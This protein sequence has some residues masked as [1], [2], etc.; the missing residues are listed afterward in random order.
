MEKLRS[1]TTRNRKD[2]PEA[3]SS[4][5]SVNLDSVLIAIENMKHEVNENIN[6]NADKIAGLKRSFEQYQENWTDA[7]VEYTNKVVKLDENL[8]SIT[9]TVEQLS[10]AV[11]EIGEKI[12]REKLPIEEAG[13]SS[14]SDNPTQKATK[15]SAKNKA[16]TLHKYVKS[17]VR[18]H[19]DQARKVLDRQ[20]P[21]GTKVEWNFV[22]DLTKGIRKPENEPVLN[23]YIAYFHDE[24]EAQS[25]A[26]C[27]NLF[28]HT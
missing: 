6:S 18:M 20:L 21:S 13:E 8:G 11:I 17:K 3:S 16:P 1:R 27:T 23:A 10:S 7:N 14:L 22:F 15:D 2:T 25:K 28:I 26:V 4:T 24:Y 12:S 5:G 19:H 9:E